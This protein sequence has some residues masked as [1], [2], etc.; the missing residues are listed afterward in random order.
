MDL[1][2][3]TKSY[4]GMTYRHFKTSR[5]IDHATTVTL[6]LSKFDFATKFP[7]GKIP[8]GVFLGL[9]TASG[10]YGPY[11]NALV[12]GV[13]VARGMLLDDC[14]VGNSLAA[15][16]AA[17]SITGDAIVSVIWEGDIIEALLPTNHGIDSLGK[18]DLGVRFKFF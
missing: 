13:E 18:A 12:T 14:S 7:N 2:V 6:D 4:G 10:K 16:T 17:A 1:A 3:R 11:D 8:S 15:G 5:G 9:I